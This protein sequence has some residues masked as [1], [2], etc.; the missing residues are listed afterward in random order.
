MVAAH[1]Q[2]LFHAFPWV[3]EADRVAGTGLPGD[4]V[5]GLLA[6]RP[7]PDP[8]PHL[9]CAVP[10][11]SICR[12]DVF[13]DLPARQKLRGSQGGIGGGLDL[14]NLAAS[15][16]L[17]PG[18]GVG[19]EPVSPAV[20]LAALHDVRFVPISGPVVGVA[21]VRI[22]L[23]IFSAYQSVALH[24]A[25]RFSRM[26]LFSQVEARSSV[27][28]ADLCGAAGLCDLPHAMDCAKLQIARSYRLCEI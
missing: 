18:V 2:R 4:V 3:R 6:F 24:Y 22:A 21:Q 17:P 23:G 15:D 1:R 12:V 28:C 27:A 8:G 5:S 19:P 26:D 7:L 20:G 11:F 9:F 16:S 13:S 14:G 25:S 10:E